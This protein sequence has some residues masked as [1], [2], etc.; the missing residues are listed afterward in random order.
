[1]GDGQA[2]VTG[3][4]VGSVEAKVKLLGG[5]RWV[6]K[7]TNPAVGGVVEKGGAC[8]SGCGLSDSGGLYRGG[9]R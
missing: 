1:M 7:G 2:G 9:K 8:N 4:T 3:H 6:E 5:G